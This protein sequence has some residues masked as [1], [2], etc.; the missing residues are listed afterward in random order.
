[1]T[2]TRPTTVVL[3]VVVGAAAG[4]LLQVA[5][6]A[7]GSPAAVPPATFALVLIVI[8]VL[9]IA[10]AL[11]V[12]RAV[13]D[14]ENH[15]VDPFYAT[16]VVALAKASGIAGSLLAGATLAILV[17]LLTR[18]VVAGVGSIL[19][20]ITA[21]V[22]AIALLVGGLVAERMCSIPPHDGDEDDR[23]PATARPH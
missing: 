7:M 12:R 21:L 11:P 20:G 3:F 14:R 22:G 15:R 19:N 6:V 23:N 10:F 2:R 9:V 1:V 4:W 17:F 18:S 8:G 13:R 5:L 16:R